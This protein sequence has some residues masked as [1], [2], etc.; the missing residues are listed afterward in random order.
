M[1]P[2]D[3]DLHQSDASHRPTVMHRLRN[4]FLTGTIIAAPLFLTIYIT[5]TFV[6]WVDSIV[7]PFRQSFS[8]ATRKASR[9]PFQSNEELSMASMK[10]PFGK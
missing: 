7:T 2:E 4:Y 8:V 1:D 9:M 6:Q 3:T 10:S 5:W